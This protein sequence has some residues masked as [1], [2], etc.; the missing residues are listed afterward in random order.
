MTSN[1]YRGPI[2]TGMSGKLPKRAFEHRHRLADGFT[3]KYHLGRIVYYEVHPDAR[4]AAARER[5][6]K[7]W[8]RDWKI[9]LIEEMNPDWRDLYDDI[10]K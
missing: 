9:R 3:K 6:I 4:S 1:K 7:K 8:N 5:A 2:Y 10:C